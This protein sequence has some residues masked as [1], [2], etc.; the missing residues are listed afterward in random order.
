MTYKIF[1]NENLDRL[2]HENSKLILFCSF[3]TK[4]E[5]FTSDI[6]KTADRISKEF[7]FGNFEYYET[8]NSDPSQAWNDATYKDKIDPN[9]TKI[10]IQG[11]EPFSSNT[12][13]SMLGQ[14][15]KEAQF[16]NM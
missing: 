12:K 2:N 15:F 11:P 14:G 6:C 8:I 16:Y 5:A 7:M 3:K 4:E 10:V 9:A 13:T 1:G